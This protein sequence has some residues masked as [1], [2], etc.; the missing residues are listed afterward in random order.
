MTRSLCGHP[1]R[2]LRPKPGVA[3]ERR[4]GDT[5]V[6]SELPPRAPR[7]WQRGQHPDGRGTSAAPHPR[8]QNERH[9]HWDT[10]RPRPPATLRP[11]GAGTSGGPPAPHTTVGVTS[12]WPG[13]AGGLSA[14]HLARTVHHGS[15]QGRAPWR[16]TPLG[17]VTGSERGLRWAFG[18][19]PW[20]GNPTA[21]GLCGREPAI[22]PA[23]C[24]WV[25]TFLGTR[26]LAG[27]VPRWVGTFPSLPTPGRTAVTGT[28]ILHVPGTGGAGSA[29]QRARGSPRPP[30]ASIVH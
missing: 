25:P 12:Q 24:L 30:G 19:G 15:P 7:T 29:G 18:P 6:A 3:D 14:E 13:R 9:Q 17:Q 28:K 10:L 8:D 2:Y 21:L 16:R 1:N 22:V 26:C 27:W 23:M 20:C 5:H 11:E 4:N